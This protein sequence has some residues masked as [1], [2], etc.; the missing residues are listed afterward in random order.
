MPAKSGVSSI[1][2][3]SASWHLALV[4]ASASDRST[5]IV[6]ESV[7]SADE[8]RQQRLF[9]RSKMA[10]SLYSIPADKAV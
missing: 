1:A 2:G 5:R 7:P 10:F 8:I 6:A 3:D 4:T 9:F